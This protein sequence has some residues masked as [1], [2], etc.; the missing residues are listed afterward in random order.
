LLF[1]YLAQG[2]ADWWP[3][4]AVDPDLIKRDVEGRERSICSIL[5]ECLGTAKPIKRLS[6]KTLEVSFL[7][8]ALD[9]HSKIIW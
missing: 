5:L 9:R 8:V 1:P 3:E 7:F 4:I 2:L 6:K